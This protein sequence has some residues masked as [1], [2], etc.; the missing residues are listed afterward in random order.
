MA[1]WLY[2]D[3]SSLCLASSHCD[4]MCRCLSENSWDYTKA[5]Q[6]FM[7]L[8]VRVLSECRSLLFSSCSRQILPVLCW[9]FFLMLII[10]V[11]YASWQHIQ[12]SH[13]TFKHED[14]HRIRNVESNI[15]ELLQ[16]LLKS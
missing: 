3:D 14:K 15:Q 7:E 5:A 9:L 2:R 10:I 4:A 16:N 8:N 11:Y 12:N 1:Y 13:K 6:V